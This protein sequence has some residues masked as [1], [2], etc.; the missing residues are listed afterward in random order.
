MPM[1]D[2]TIIQTVGLRKVY[3]M[4]ETETVALDRGDIVTRESLAAMTSP[5]VQTQPG[6]ADLNY[7]LGWYVQDFEGVRMVWHTGRW[8]PSTSALYLKVPE[9]RLT[10]II[11]ANTDNLTVPFPG[12]G[13]GDLSRSAPMLTFFHHFVSP[14]VSGAEFATQRKRGRSSPFPSSTAK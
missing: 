5:A 8:P 7:G 3:Q 11:A 9:Y 10:F 4:G 13:G 2:Q 14:L 1:R 12:I 6:R